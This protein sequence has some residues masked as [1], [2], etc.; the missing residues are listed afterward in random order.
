METYHYQDSGVLKEFEGLSA[1]EIQVKCKNLK[2]ICQ[3]FESDTDSFVVINAC[4]SISL[5]IANKEN[6]Y[7]PLKLSFQK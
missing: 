4:N 1:V 5:F 3:F 7:V 2:F 6:K